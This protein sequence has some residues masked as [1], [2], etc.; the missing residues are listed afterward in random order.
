MKYT[1][2]QIKILKKKF[3]TSQ[4]AIKQ[5]VDRE[6]NEIRRCMKLFGN[7][8]ILK[9]DKLEK[10]IFRRG[11]L[12]E[13]C[14]IGFNSS[15]SENN[16]ADIKLERLKPNKRQR[17][18]G[19]EGNMSIT[20]QRI[21][22]QAATCKQVMEDKGWNISKDN[23][24]VVFYRVI[25]PDAPIEE[26]KIFRGEADIAFIPTNTTSFGETI[27]IVDLKSTGS[28]ANQFGAFAGWGNHQYM[29][30]LQAI[31]YLWAASD[32]DFE[33]NDILNP[34]NN[35]RSAIISC[36]YNMIKKKNPDI[37]I[38]Y[39]NLSKEEELLLSNMVLD[40]IKKGSLTF[41]YDVWDWSPNKG[42]LIVPVEIEKESSFLLR[43][44]F[45]KSNSILEDIFAY[46]NEH[47]E[48]KEEPH[49]TLCEQCHIKNC[50][51]RDSGEFLY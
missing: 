40:L 41:V 21:R 46:Y 48:F 6:G 37:D 19:H 30:K 2:D 42:H 34:G 35:L 26:W 23:T 25:N 18:L 3:K 28:I 43:E 33:L 22:E 29:N 7:T 32:I 50:K 11:N 27:S 49:P 36:G 45:R 8:Y 17:L 24:Q 14:A 39:S 44:T 20:E 12:F 13:H 10:E 5:L 31:S 38:D 9:T 47:N 4:S 51:A 1:E 15:H 16:E